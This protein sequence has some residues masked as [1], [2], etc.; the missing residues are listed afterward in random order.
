LEVVSI[1]YAIIQGLTMG[2]RAAEIELS[3]EERA[4]LERWRRRRTGSAGLHFRAEIVLDCAEGYSGEE[5]AERHRTSQ[6]TVTK[7][8]RRFVQ[9]R[10]AGL[11]DAPRSGQ[12]RR[13]DDAK[14]QEVLEATLHR[15]SG[16]AR[17]RSEAA[18]V[19]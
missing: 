9:D 5:I 8:R 2:R 1:G 13:H 10:L 7:W 3:D 6:Q 18:S 15:R 14:V 4:E 16:L 12:P 19:A 17:L 11:S